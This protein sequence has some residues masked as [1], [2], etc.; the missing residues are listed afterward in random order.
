MDGARGGPG[1]GFRFRAPRRR[2]SLRARGEARAV[3]R[4][5]GLAAGLGDPVPRAHARG[6]GPRARADIHRSGA[7][8]K[9]LAGRGD[10]REPGAERG[11]AGRR[12]RRARHRGRRPGDIQPFQPQGSRAA[13]AGHA[14]P[15]RRL[16]RATAPLGAFAAHGGARRRRVGL[17]AA[18]YVPGGARA[19]Q[20]D[21]GRAGG[22]PRAARPG[23]P[24]GGAVR[25]RGGAPRGDRGRG[26]LPLG[27][28][29]R[30]ERRGV[31]GFGGRAELRLPPG[32]YRYAASD[33]GGAERGIVAVETYSD[34]WR[35]AV[36]ILVPQSGTPGVQLTSVA[37]RD[38]WWLFVVVI[39]ALVAEWA[40]RRREGLS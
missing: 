26:T 4:A 10:A 15:R 28:P 3:R 27:L 24:D 23:T 16:V 13:L 21:H 37:L 31:S 12:R 25:A 29:R 1:G 38:R 32:V 35:P 20:L 5:P 39:A 17:T 2:A 40:W 34:E 30:C 9:P 14:A 11:G 6:R 33:G 19:R 22:A 7:R 8:W 18:R 36:P